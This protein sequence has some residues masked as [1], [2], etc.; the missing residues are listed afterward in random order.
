MEILEEM[1]WTLHIFLHFLHL[2]HLRK[3]SRFLAQSVVTLLEIRFAG[4]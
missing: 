2:L 4:R 1:E 3:C